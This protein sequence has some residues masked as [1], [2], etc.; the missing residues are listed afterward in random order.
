MDFET[1]IPFKLALDY[2]FPIS[3]LAMNFETHIIKALLG[4]IKVEH[5]TFKL[6]RRD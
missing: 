3:H 6:Q 5:I 1:C 2:I 4:K